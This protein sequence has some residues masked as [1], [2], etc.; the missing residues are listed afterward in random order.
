MLIGAR[1]PS[2]AYGATEDVGEGAHAPE[3]QLFDPVEITAFWRAAGPKKWFVKDDA[4]DAELRTRFLD[5]HMA[6]ARREL[7]HWL[8][9]SE[10]ALALLLLLDQVP[11][12]IF[13]GTAHQFAADPLARWAAERALAAGH[14]QAVEPALRPFFFLPFEHSE[15]AADQARSVA[16]F[17]VLDDAES[18]KWAEVHAEILARFGRFPHRNAPLGRESTAGEI[19]FLASGGFGG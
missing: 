4:F 7:D 15:T 10:G 1:A 12:N 14:D 9:T 11:R 16:L 19:A 13:R 6:A 3:F 8:E 5:A 2:S 17:T 18:L